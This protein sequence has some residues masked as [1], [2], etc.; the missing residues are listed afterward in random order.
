MWFLIKLTTTNYQER[1]D[2]FTYCLTALKLKTQYV[3]KGSLLTRVATQQGKEYLSV[4]VI[5]GEGLH[6]YIKDSVG[7]QVEPA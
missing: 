6:Q 3:D 5:A 7:V 2:T 4:V 1:R